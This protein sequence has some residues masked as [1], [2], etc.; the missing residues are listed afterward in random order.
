[1]VLTGF[2][3][4]ASALTDAHQAILFT[5]GL[6][7]REIYLIGVG[8][9]VVTFPSGRLRTTLERVL[10]W[11]AVALLTVVEVVVLL[12][13]SPERCRLCPP[14]N[15]LAIAPN[16]TVANLLTQLQRLS[17]LTLIVN[18]A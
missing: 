11:S 4:F 13:Y 17:G 6:V 8:Y 10:I 16:N 1:M 5:V 12:F 2:A 15:L 14:S 3:W 18:P 9:V 7:V